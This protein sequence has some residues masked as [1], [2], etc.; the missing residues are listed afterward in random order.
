MKQVII[1]AGGKGTRLKE[2]LGDLPKPLIDI[3]GIPLLERQILLVKEYGFDN[4]LILVNY[5]SNKI[6]DFCNLKNNWGINITC[7][8]D[9]V[10]LGTA[11]AILRIFDHL[12]S[13]FLVMYGDTMLDVDLNSFYKYHTEDQSAAATIFLHPNDHPADS[14]LVEINEDGKVIEFHPYPHDTSRYYP[15]LVNAALYWIKKEKIAPWKSNTG[16]LD[17]GKDLFPQMLSKNLCIKAYNC[18]EYIKDCGTPKRLD[19]VCN[20]FLTG[21]IARSSLKN[22]QKA[23]FLDRDG[24]INEEIDHLNKT[25]QFKLLKGVNEAIKELNGSDYLTCVVTNQPVV[26]RGEC[27]LYE[28]KQ[29]HNKMETLLGQNGAFINRIYYCPHHPDSGYPGE[30]KELKFNCSCRKPNTGMLDKAFI[31]LN[32]QSNESWFIG[33]SSSDILT[34]KK[35]GLKS[36]LVETGY[37]GLDQKFWATPDFIVPDIHKAVRFILK[38]YLQIYQYCLKFIPL[39]NPGDTIVIGG[40]SRSGKTTFAN[41]LRQVLIDNDIQSHVLSID[42]WLKSENERKDGVLQRYNIKEIET[43]LKSVR[44]INSRPLKIKLPGYHKLKRKQYPAI[45]EI[46]IKEMDV[47]ILE[48]TIALEIDKSFEINKHQ[49]YIQMDEALRK[50]RVINEYLLRG[51]S[52]EEATT[53]YSHRSLDETPI[54]VNTS[55][56]VININMDQF[57]I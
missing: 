12:A 27:S 5:A 7:I 57:Y 39:I 23:V 15:N 9:G 28:L 3:C 37:A 29:I 25:E 8:D 55:D 21:K 20:D 33:D 36:I 52:I 10:P 40:L 49:F 22:N 32:I 24:T 14:D 44:E 47:I 43:I 17:F 41:V 30:I 56:K 38:N 18:T 35:A 46:E 45:E 4:V 48:G 1:L 53:V 19:K 34:A 54:I 26:A 16:M 13:E 50:E 6:I 31:E 51:N 2:R 11:G 42:R